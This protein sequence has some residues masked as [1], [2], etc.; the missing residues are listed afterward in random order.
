[1][2]VDHRS[3]VLGGDRLVAVMTALIALELN[4]TM[5][6]VFCVVLVICTII[7]LAGE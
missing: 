3:P 2:V 5:T 1:M 4:P 6:I 7:L